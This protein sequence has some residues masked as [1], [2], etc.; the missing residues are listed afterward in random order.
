[1]GIFA[2][3]AGF[4]YNDFFSVGLRLFPS[5]YQDTDGD[6]QFT[7]TW[8]TTNSGGQ[9]PYPFGVDWAWIGASNELL[10]INSLKMKL[11]VLFGVLQMTLGVFLRWSNALY[12]KNLTDFI[13]EC[14]PMMIF[15][16]CFFGFMD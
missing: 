12:E 15:L 9:G 14:V 3:F 16:L 5:R 11:S 10:Y 7:P 13:C 4:M 1:M 6:G 8:D 2:T